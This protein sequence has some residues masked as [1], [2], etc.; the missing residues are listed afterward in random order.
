MQTS[1]KKLIGAWPTGS[2]AGDSEDPRPAFSP[3]SLQVRPCR[4]PVAAEL[5]RPSSRCLAG[6]I[7][8]NLEV[9]L[10]WLGCS[11]L[12]AASGRKDSYCLYLKESIVVRASYIVC[13]SR[14]LLSHVR[15]QKTS[16]FYLF[17]FLKKAGGDKW[18][19]PF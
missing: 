7:C 12:F 13:V 19:F 5:H 4:G 2:G 6:P 15:V 9:E 14:N 18:A 17:L 11:W 3:R 10:W 8:S 16:T 1:P